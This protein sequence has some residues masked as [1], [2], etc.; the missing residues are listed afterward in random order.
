MDKKEKLLSIK[1]EVKYLTKSKL[2]LQG[3]NK[4]IQV[5]KSYLEY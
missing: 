5:V 3:G 4:Y 2:V 1:S